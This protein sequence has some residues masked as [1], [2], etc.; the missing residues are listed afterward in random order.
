M[1]FD[2]VQMNYKIGFKIWLWLILWIND[3]KRIFNSW[4]MLIHLV[5]KFW[6]TFNPLVSTISTSLVNSIWCFGELKNYLYNVWKNLLIGT[7]RQCGQALNCKVDFICHIMDPNEVRHLLSLHYN[8]NSKSNPFKC[9][10]TI[11]SQTHVI[12]LTC[13]INSCSHY[14]ILCISNCKKRKK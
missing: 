4:S 7:H 12:A 13:T 5:F 2:Q 14:L 1:P 8:Y 9:W 3:P 10:S 6:K 11:N